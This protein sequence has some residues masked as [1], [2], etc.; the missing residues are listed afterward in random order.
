MVPPSCHVMTGRH[1][2][3]GV[4]PAAA[5]SRPGRAGAT[6]SRCA[7]QLGRISGAAGAPSQPAFVKFGMN[8]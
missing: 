6:A 4:I 2:G 8:R 3:S 1:P 7:R 5:S